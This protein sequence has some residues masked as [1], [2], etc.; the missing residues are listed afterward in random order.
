MSSLEFNPDDPQNWLLG[1]RKL[2]SLWIYKTKVGRGT[3]K[4]TDSYNFS[5]PVS[6][7][8]SQTN[9]FPIKEGINY[10]EDNLNNIYMQISSAVREY[11]RS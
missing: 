9:I 1:V 10:S 6:K 8:T 4:F 11:S 5:V 2:F 7:S 3:I